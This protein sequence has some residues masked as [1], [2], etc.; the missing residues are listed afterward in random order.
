MHFFIIVKKVHSWECNSMQLNL[1]KVR[2]IWAS[3]S[4]QSEF[5]NRKRISLFTYE[6]GVLGTRSYYEVCYLLFQY[7]INHF[8]A[9]ISNL[10]RGISPLKYAFR[11]HQ[12]VLTV[13]FIQIKI[14]WI[15]LFIGLTKRTFLLYFSSAV[16]IHFC[17]LWSENHEEI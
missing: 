16:S 13:V 8:T 10:N 17:D 11:K 2:T 3:V 1:P 9:E 12:Y 6:K 5:I 14:V 4:N 7:S 15:E